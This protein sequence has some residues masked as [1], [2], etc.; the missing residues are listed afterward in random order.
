MHFRPKN[1]LSTIEALLTE[2]EGVRVYLPNMETLRE[3]VERSMD[4]IA[5]A[6]LMLKSIPHP[7]VEQLK[8]LAVKA[9]ALPVKLD[10]LQDVSIDG[11]TCNKIR[12]FEV[13]GM[14]LRSILDR[15]FIYVF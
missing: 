3:H 5:K 2:S 14:L 13:V 4:W 9:R 12:V 11:R 15:F 1:T 6:E 7:A 10:L 8:N